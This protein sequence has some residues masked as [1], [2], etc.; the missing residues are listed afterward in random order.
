MLRC[1]FLEIK[2]HFHFHKKNQKALIGFKCSCEPRATSGRPRLWLLSILSDQPY[3]V[4]PTLGS[5]LYFQVL[6]WPS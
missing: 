5:P 6:F 1:R 4:S 3:R 2:I